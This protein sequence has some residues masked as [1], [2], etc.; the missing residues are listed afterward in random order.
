MFF[1]SGIKRYYSVQ[2]IKR[3]KAPV[4]LYIVLEKCKL[5]LNTNNNDFKSMR[6][7]SEDIKASNNIL[8]KEECAKLRTPYQSPLGG[9]CFFLPVSYN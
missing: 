5:L 4:I 3:I 8:Q 1:R 7:I 6:R 9:S 2:N